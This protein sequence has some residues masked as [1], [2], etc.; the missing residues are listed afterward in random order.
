MEIQF[1]ITIGR[2]AIEETGSKKKERERDKIEENKA[3]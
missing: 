2:M 3:S 1:G